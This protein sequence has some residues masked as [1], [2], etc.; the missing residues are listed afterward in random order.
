M[1]KDIDMVSIY[2]LIVK[3][4]NYQIYRLIIFSPILLTN[5]FGL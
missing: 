5:K 3:M 4:K 2:L 1:K